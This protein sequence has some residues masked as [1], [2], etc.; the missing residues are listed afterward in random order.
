MF[1]ATET[2]QETAYGSRYVPGIGDLPSVR[3]TISRTYDVHRCET[4]GRESSS[5]RLAG[6]DRPSEPFYCSKCGALVRVD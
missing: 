6:D 2:R 5:L 3:G 4:C 1:I